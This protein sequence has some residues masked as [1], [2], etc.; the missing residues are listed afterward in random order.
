MLPLRIRDCSPQAARAEATE[1]TLVLRHRSSPAVG[2][3]VG[4]S[5]VGHPSGSLECECSGC[6]TPV[7]RPGLI[8][9]ATGRKDGGYSGASSSSSL[10]RLRVPLAAP[11]PEPQPE[12]HGALHPA[13]PFRPVSQPGGA[14]SS[15]RR[16]QPEQGRHPGLPC[17]QG[18]PGGAEETL[19][20]PLHCGRSV[21][22]FRRFIT[23]AV[24]C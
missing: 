12:A 14:S 18:L 5:S 13:T 4:P 24:C 20:P 9:P 6:W 11:Q 16:W 22:G 3:D 17:P 23:P 19:R 10:R 15:S 7:R 21:A 2:V 1:L 8:A